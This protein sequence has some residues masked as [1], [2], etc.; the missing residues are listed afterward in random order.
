MRHL[1]HGRLTQ[2]VNGQH[3]DGQA[4]DLL[5]PISPVEKTEGRM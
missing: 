2:L 5:L 4:V 3:T 1:L